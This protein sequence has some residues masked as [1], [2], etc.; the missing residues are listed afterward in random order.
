LFANLVERLIEDGGCRKERVFVTL[1]E[2]TLGEQ[3]VVE[4]GAVE[5]AIYCGGKG[6][7]MFLLGYEDLAGLG[8]CA[9]GEGDRPLL[10]KIVVER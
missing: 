8:G 3:S 10:C 2:R 5:V 9:L 7:G 1:V 4:F 6:F